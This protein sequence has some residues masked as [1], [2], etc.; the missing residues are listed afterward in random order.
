MGELSGV[1]SEYSSESLPCNT[2]KWCHLTIEASQIIRNS[3]VWQ[4]WFRLTIEKSQKV[5]IT[6]SITS[7]LSPQ[8]PVMQKQFSCHN[9][10]MRTPLYL[11]YKIFCLVYGCHVELKDLIWDQTKHP[12]LFLLVRI[13]IRG[14]AGWDEGNLTC[15]MVNQLQEMKKKSYMYLRLR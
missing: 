9:V 14:F 1:C 11:W 10:T 2:L 13:P 4:I 3:T 6:D 5:H 12:V 8:V 7:P 15:C